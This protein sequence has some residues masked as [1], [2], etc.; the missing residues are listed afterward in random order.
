MK[1]TLLLLLPFISGSHACLA[2]PCHFYGNN[3][4]G[5][6]KNCEACTECNYSNDDTKRSND[7]WCKNPVCGKYKKSDGDSTGTSGRT[8]P[9]T[10]HGLCG[11]TKC[12]KGVRK[13][14]TPIL[15][16]FVVF[17][18]E[19]KSEGMCKQKE[20]GPETDSMKCCKEKCPHE[21][22]ILNK[23]HCQSVVCGQDGHTYTGICALDEC[24][25]TVCNL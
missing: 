15:H 3:H 22:E 17:S 1:F 7:M 6:S 4:V 24:G 12:A 14:N 9:I 25:K 2:K 13:S 21:N 11:L 19:V 10:Y 16:V 8:C 5:H 20:S 23:A 18:Q